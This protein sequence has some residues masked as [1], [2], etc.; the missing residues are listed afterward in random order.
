MSKRAHTSHRGPSQRQLRV[1]EL[2]RRSLTDVLLRGDLHD[3]ALAGTSIIVSEARATPDLKKVTA[4]IST[5]NGENEDEVL[6][7]LKR[8][9]KHLRHEVM[10]GLNLKFAPA[11]IFEIDR[12]FDRMD[13]TRRMFSDPKVVQDLDHD[14]E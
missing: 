1:G 7:A 9:A 3:E 8:S 4:Y 6:A 11:L 5:L 13:E 14:I 10:Q 2:I 12:S